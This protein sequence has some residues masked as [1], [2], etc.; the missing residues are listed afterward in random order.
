VAPLLLKTG[1]AGAAER[2][3]PVAEGALHPVQLP[4]GCMGVRGGRTVNLIPPG[5]GF[6]ATPSP[7]L[8]TGS[9]GVEDSVSAPDAKGMGAAGETGPVQGITG[10]SGSAPGEGGEGGGE[11]GED[12]GNKGEESKDDDGG[13]SGGGGATPLPDVGCEPAAPEEGLVP[14]AV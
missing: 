10:G 11:G 5:T 9:K 13:N 2:G 1:C 12:E 6:P 4:T 8:L 3:N 7:A 14:G